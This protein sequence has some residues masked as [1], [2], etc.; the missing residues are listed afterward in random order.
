MEEERREEVQGQ[1]VSETPAE[2]TPEAP[3]RGGFSFGWFFLGLIIGALLVLA[4][5]Y[6]TW[7]IPLDSANEQVKTLEAQVQMAQDR[8]EK[9]RR[10]LSRAQEALTALNEAL[11]ELSPKTSQ[12]AQTTPAPTS[13]GEPPTQ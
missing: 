13:E 7:K 4:I 6:P 1:E 8:V 10:A 11:Q 2:A 5:T 3:R 12:P 9:M